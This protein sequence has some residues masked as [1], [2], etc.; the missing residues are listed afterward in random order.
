M[1]PK[2][3]MKWRN[4]KANKSIQSI[5][6]IKSQNNYIEPLLDRL[7]SADKHV[8]ISGIDK[9]AK[10]FFI[11]QLSHHLNK[12]LYISDIKGD[13]AY[14]TCGE[15][16]CFLNTGVNHLRG[17][18]LDLNK[19]IYSSYSDYVLE[20]TGWLYKS[21][22]ADLTVCDLQCLFEKVIPEKI[23]RSFTIELCIDKAISRDDKFKTI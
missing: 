17:R 21:R 5:F 2:S 4:V 22:E 16:S 6:S 18:N 1:L 3:R 19:A 23:L 7:N 9:R 8:Y 13:E 11:S 12:I 14:K 20:K 10:H 15:L